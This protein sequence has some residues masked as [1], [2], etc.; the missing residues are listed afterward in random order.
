MYT[1]LGQTFGPEN[2]FRLV[3]VPLWV[4]AVA[5]NEPNFKDADDTE[6]T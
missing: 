6:P 5:A 4:T 1:V 3:A 2:K